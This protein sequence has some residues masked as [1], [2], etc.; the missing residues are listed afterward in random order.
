M[1]RKENTMKIKLF[2]LLLF[3]AGC[4]DTAWKTA[5]QNYTCSKEQ[6]DRVISECE[7]CIER[8]RLNPN[9]CYNVAIMNNCSKREVKE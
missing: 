6:R 2:I 5:P 9:Y 4:T 8:A 1:S 7:Y 3:I